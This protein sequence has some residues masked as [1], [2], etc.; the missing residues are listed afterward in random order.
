M[1]DPKKL[2]GHQEWP[3][4]VSVDHEN[5]VEGHYDFSD[6]SAKR[7]VRAKYEKGADCE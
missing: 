7:E 4:L 3:P 1:E 5:I 6:D 2:Y